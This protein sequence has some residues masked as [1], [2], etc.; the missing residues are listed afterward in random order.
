MK[1][2]F[3]TNIKA[4]GKANI[5]RSFQILFGKEIWLRKRH[6]FYLKLYFYSSSFSSSSSFLNLSWVISGNCFKIIKFIL[7]V[8]YQPKIRMYSKYESRTDKR[9]YKDRKKLYKGVLRIFNTKIKKLIQICQEIFI[10]NNN[11][12]L[13]LNLSLKIDYFLKMQIMTNH[14]NLSSRSL[15]PFPVGLKRLHV[16]ETSSYVY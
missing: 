7:E 8:F 11:S 16:L 10:Y 6:A 13:D 4:R 3:K 2:N 9:T 14:I 1:V 12:R 15:T 5:K